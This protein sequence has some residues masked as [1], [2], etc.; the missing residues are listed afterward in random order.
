MRADGTW[1]AHHIKDGQL[2]YDWNKDRRFS[3][4]RRGNKGTLEYNQQF[5]LYKEMFE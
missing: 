1:E 4:L 2:I 5:E 3:A